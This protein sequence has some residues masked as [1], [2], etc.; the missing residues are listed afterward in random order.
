M[1]ESPKEALLRAGIRVLL[2]MLGLAGPLAAQE[3]SH[4]RYSINAVQVPEGPVLDGVLDDA[5]WESGVLIDNF[6]QQEP[7][8]AQ[9]DLGRGTVLHTHERFATLPRGCLVR[10]TARCLTAR[11][12]RV[13]LQKHPSLLRSVLNQAR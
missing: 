12:L 9:D 5:V 7:D 3:D 6:V 8:E 10:M 13:E 2:L 1:L 11:S 4:S